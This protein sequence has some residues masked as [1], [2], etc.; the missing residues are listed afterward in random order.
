VVVLA[1]PFGA[2]GI[3]EC[4]AGYLFFNTKADVVYDGMIAIAFGV[5]L[6]TITC[7][8]QDTG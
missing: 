8:F 6:R 3:T 7:V 1:A 2:R 5:D 4:F